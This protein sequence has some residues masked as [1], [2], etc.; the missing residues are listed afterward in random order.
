MVKVGQR[1]RFRHGKV[2]WTV[3]NVTD[4]WVSLRA[5]SGKFEVETVGHLPLRAT[6][7][8]D[9]ERLKRS[10]FGKFAWYGN[11]L[12]L[13]EHDDG[14]LAAGEVRFASGDLSGMIDYVDNLTDIS[15]GDR[16]QGLTNSGAAPVV[17]GTVVQPIRMADLTIEFDDGFKVAEYVGWR[18]I[19][20]VIVTGC[21]YDEPISLFQARLRST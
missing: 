4:H 10:W 18:G 16:V 3:E 19:S 13:M 5:P 6:L 9:P 7:L 20:R 14:G 2:V 1:W 17:L 11:A 8:L 12:A 21:K 15:V